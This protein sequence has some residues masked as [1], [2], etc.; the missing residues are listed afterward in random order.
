M[1]LDRSLSESAIEFTQQITESILVA[2]DIFLVAF[3]IKRKRNM[4]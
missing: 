2:A 4:L 1:N 3:F